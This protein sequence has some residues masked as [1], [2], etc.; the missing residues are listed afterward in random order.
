MGSGHTRGMKTLV[1]ALLLA[2]FVPVAAWAE[3]CAPDVLTVRTS[4]GQA[5]FAVEVADTAAARGQGLMHRR[6]M[7]PDAGML[8]VYPAPRRVRFWM[9]NTYIPLDMIFADA[10][11]VVR[12]VHAGAVPHDETPIDGGPDIQFVLEVNAG[13][14]AQAGIAPGAQLRHPAIGPRAAW[15]CG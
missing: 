2:L 6:E 11:G 10:R 9:K 14:A 12:H 8:F 4:Q 3:S 15:P 1:L 13:I 5:R 7:A